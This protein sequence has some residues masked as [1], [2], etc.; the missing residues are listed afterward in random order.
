[1]FELKCQNVSS[2]ASFINHNI[3]HASLHFVG[4]FF[5]VIYVKEMSE[6]YQFNGEE[7]EEE[8]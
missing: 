1:M 8:T 7:E 6:T 3:C 2:N 4:Q 5:I